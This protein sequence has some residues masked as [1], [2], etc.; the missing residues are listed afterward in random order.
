MSDA[1]S[2]A[3][4]ATGSIPVVIPAFPPTLPSLGGVLPFMQSWISGQ[5]LRGVEV[6]S[7]PPA[8]LI[9]YVTT[10][11]QLS[12]VPA[13]PSHGQQVSHLRKDQGMDTQSWKWLLASTLQ[14]LHC[15]PQQS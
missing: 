4:E 6:P 9:L 1:P 12:K 10:P 15:A 13:A 2:L 14:A 3:E 8:L 5:G 11:W 7:A